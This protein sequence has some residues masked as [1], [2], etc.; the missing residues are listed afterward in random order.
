M[1]YDANGKWIPESASVSEGVTKL[2][3]EGSSFTERAKSDANLAANR[4]G[5]R[6]SSIAIQAGEEAA[7]KAALPIASQE[8][9]QIQQQ[10]LQTQG[11]QFQT[12]E[13]IA[14]RAFKASE[15]LAGRKLQASESAF[16]RELTQSES[17]AA[18]ALQASESAF[19]RK[20]TQ[21]ESEAA[22][23]FQGGES[24]ADRIARQG[25]LD[26][27]LASREEISEADRVQRTELQASQI[28]ST[29]S[30]A[31]LDNDTRVAITNLNASSQQA[32]A[33]LG[34]TSA[35]E[36]K[37]VDAAVQYAA[38]Y[39]RSLTAIQQNKDLPSE[40]RNKLI[41]HIGDLRDSNFKMVTQLS[42]VPLSWS[43]GEDLTLGG[44]QAT[45]ASPEL[46]SALKD[47]T[48]S[49]DSN[50]DLAA[51]AREVLEQGG[52]TDAITDG[53][54]F[55]DPNSI[56]NEANKLEIDLSAYLKTPTPPPTPPPTP[57]PTPVGFYRLFDGNFHQV[58]TGPY[59]DSRA[60]DE[61][62]GYDDN[63]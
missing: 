54:G 13:A 52:S 45:T 32:I 53:G 3:G 4:R 36:L 49:E 58:G 42:D 28:F 9:T 10:N 31:A 24:A 23:V 17:E 1:A 40:Y 27:E 16:G 48:L 63:V 38:Q 20:L 21:S 22:R 47:S 60:G 44:E 56:L 14:E 26:T 25:L 6:N 57:D 8:A 19:G 39:E 2:I 35:N 46:L 18:R 12:Q 37:A 51:V 5:L 62:V 33:Q 7:Q 61:N 50:Y 41:S 43:S 30:L 15:S 55:P 59:P 34:V 11:E 29:E